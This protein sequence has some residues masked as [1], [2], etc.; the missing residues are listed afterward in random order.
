MIP[1][2]NILVKVI[3]VKVVLICLA[4]MFFTGI[5]TSANNSQ[6]VIL[7]VN[8]F[9]IGGI[10]FGRYQ[11]SDIEQ[12]FGAPIRVLDRQGEPPWTQYWFNGVIIDNLLVN[13]KGEKK[14]NSMIINSPRLSTARGVRVGDSLE[15]VIK[16]Y[17]EGYRVVSNNGLIIRYQLADGR[18]A[19]IE[20]IFSVN[21][22]DKIVE[23]I[24]YYIRLEL[25]QNI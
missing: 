22:F 15:D 8:D 10:L 11:I 7:E 14:V 23:E 25:I 2:N 13:Y 5:A 18:P 20:F 19:Y 24:R 17:G 21:G 16:T 6:G 9:E 1:E 4:F 12:V 3:S